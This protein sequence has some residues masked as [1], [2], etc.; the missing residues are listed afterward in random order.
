MSTAALRA[1]PADGFVHEAFIYRE[2]DQAVAQLGGFIRDGLA[3]D[4]PVLV[5]LPGARLD[6]VRHELGDTTADLTLVDLQELG[7]NPGRITA[8][9]H[10]WISSHPGQ[11]LRGIGEPVWPGRSAAEVVECH[12]HERLLNLACEGSRLWLVC[13]YDAT[14][15]SAEVLSMAQDAHP[16]VVAD[17]ERQAVESSGGA[18]DDVLRAPLEEPDDVAVDIEFSHHPADVRRHTIK[19]A[20]A[21][22]L[23]AERIE[24]LVLA[25][26]EVATNSLRHAAGV[27]RYRMWCDS[28]SLVAE[29][30]DSGRI[31]QPLVGRIPPGP[32]AQDGRGLWMTHQLCDLVQLR[33]G[34]D[35]T[36]VR[37]HMRLNGS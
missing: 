32:D 25:I 33:S 24:D 13:P 15:L 18:W 9:W 5:A 29:V 2:P 6:R 22:G 26:N 7:R 30:R 19:Q 36:V 12:T 20:A 8:V 23:P 34:A 14:A 11:P 1:R 37:L 3:R 27:G 17:D 31:R 10:D 35:G 16:F 21:A 4:E 28:S